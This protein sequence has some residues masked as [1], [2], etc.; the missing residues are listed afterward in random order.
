[1]QYLHINEYVY[2][3]KYFFEESVNVTIV[4]VSMSIW[5]D[6][7]LSSDWGQS[8]YQDVLPV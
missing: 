7:V 6:M 5:E 8:Q 2:L 4:L 3:A 1:M